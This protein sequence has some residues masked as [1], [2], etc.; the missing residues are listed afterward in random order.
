MLGRR[1]ITAAASGAIASVLPLWD[2]A[3]FWRSVAGLLATTVL[4]LLVAAVI[5]RD[6]PDFAEL[7]VLCVLRDDGRQPAWSV[8]LAAA[9]HQ[10]AVD[11]LSPPAPPAGKT[12][13]LWL[14]APDTALRPLALLPLS[15]RKILPVTPENTRRL[16][17]K[18][19]LRVT[20]EPATGTLAG[21]PS[22]P[23][24]YRAILE[25]RY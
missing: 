6:P 7:R 17:K 8:R 4:A 19:E 15:G 18:G 1:V 2:N 21:A 22:G 16:A 14:A 12:Y 3:R 25:P 10:I 9:A 20:L 23:V 5:S 24:I 11:G 13:Q